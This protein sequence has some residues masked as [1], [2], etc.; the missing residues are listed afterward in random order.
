MR[1]AAELA[2]RGVDV[3]AE[4][5]TKIENPDRKAQWAF[6]SPALDK[7]P[8][9][10]FESL[11]DVKNRAKEPWVLEGL[12]YLHHPRRGDWGERLIRPSLNL[13][14]EIQQT[15]D[16]FFPQRWMAATLG[17]YRSAAAA[18]DVRVFLASL[19][20]DYP[21]RLKLTILVAADDLFHAQPLTS[22]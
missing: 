13:L 1:L 16:I 3:R 4:Q 5:L 19:P 11:K 10:F 9:S 8:S 22:K 17:H 20:A 18:K 14:R 15:G 6:V 12:S 7:D 21:S 2:L